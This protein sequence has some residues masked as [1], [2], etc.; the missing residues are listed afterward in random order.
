[1]SGVSQYLERI[2][3]EICLGTPKDMSLCPMS[4]DLSDAW[5]AIALEVALAKER[6]ET[7]DIVWDPADVTVVTI[8]GRMPT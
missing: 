2:T 1:M 3:V 6:G 5:D 8:P 7:P 4:Q